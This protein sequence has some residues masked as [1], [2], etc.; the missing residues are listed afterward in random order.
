MSCSTT[1][2]PGWGTRGAARALEE[3]EREHGVRL[4][5]GRRPLAPDLTAEVLLVDVTGPPRGLAG[6]KHELYRR[7]GLTSDRYEA[8]PE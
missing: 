4:V 6:F 5:Y 8:D 7:F 2:S 3:V 1:A